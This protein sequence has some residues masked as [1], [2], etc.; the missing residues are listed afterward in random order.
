MLLM[1]RTCLRE[2]SGMRIDNG[3]E[4]PTP[5]LVGG[6]LERCLR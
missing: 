1:I 5:S 2:Q 4:D 3:L 6:M